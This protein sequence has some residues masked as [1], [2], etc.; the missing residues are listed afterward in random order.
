MPSLCSIPP[1]SRYFVD[2]MTVDLDEE[3]HLHTLMVDDFGVLN[4]IRALV[5]HFVEL[6]CLNR[7]SS[8]IS[9]TI[10]EG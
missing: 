1:F 4:A 2:Y 7:V 5:I 6:W 8:D 10:W 9:N 3:T